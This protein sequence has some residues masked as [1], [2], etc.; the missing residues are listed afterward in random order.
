[1]A[2]LSYAKHWPILLAGG[3]KS[4][5]DD[6]IKALKA[7]GIKKAYVVGGELAVTPAVVDQL[8]SNGVAF[9]GRLAGG[10]GVQTSREI[11]SFAL[12]NGLSV[13][14]MA[15]AT[16][17]NF[18]D[19]LAGAAL[20]GRNASVLLLCDDKAQGNLSFSTQHKD[21]IVQGYVFGGTLA[22]S[23]DLFNK[24]PV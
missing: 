19:A 20:C 12:A 18:P 3:G 22:F 23:E 15:Y 1:M 6:V 13:A 4:L 17:Q 7:C 16:S 14:N 24:L 11:A 5:N 21:D 2:P 8:T 10:T 9:A